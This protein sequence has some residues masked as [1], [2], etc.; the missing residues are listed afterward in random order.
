MIEYRYLTINILLVVVD[1]VV[2]HDL[3]DLFLCGADPVGAEIQHVVRAIRGLDV[4][5][6]SATADSVS[7]LEDQ[8]IQIRASRLQYCRCAQSGQAGS[9]DDD[10]VLRG[11][12]F[13]T[14]RNAVALAVLEELLFYQIPILQQFP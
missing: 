5:G 3:Q 7:T 11:C 9:N 1:A 6:V 10:I 13:T 4:D 14:D 2:F 8:H 12:H